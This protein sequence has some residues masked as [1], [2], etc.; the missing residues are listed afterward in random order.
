MA[1]RAARARG[2]KSS[3]LLFAV[4][5]LYYLLSGTPHTSYLT[6]LIFHPIPPCFLASTCVAC[7]ADDDDEQETA[8]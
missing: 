5:Y 3:F 1:A 4:C 6:Y 2:R 7:P 8:R